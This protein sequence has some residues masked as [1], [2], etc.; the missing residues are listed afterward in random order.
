MDLILTNTTKSTVKKKKNKQTQQQQNPQTKQKRH[1]VKEKLRGLEGRTG[2]IRDKG[3][4]AKLRLPKCTLQAG[5]QKSG[6]P[7]ANQSEHKLPHCLCG[8]K[9]MRTSEGGI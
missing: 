8:Y 2:I 5:M 9:D 7:G 1:N 4:S 3:E 6:S